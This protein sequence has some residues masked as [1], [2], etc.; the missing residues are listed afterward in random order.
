MQSTAEAD[1]EAASRTPSP[2]RDVRRDLAWM[3][4]IR[5]AFSLNVLKIAH[6]LIIPLQSPSDFMRNP[7]I[8]LLGA[9][10]KLLTGDHVNADKHAPVVCA[11]ANCDAADNNVFEWLNVTF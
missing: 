5:V 1:I 4:L 7:I 2:P 6:L 8:H 10:P 11:Q 9:L 3:L